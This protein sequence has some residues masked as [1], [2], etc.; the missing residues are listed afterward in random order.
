LS[1]PIGVAFDTHGNLFISE[2]GNNRI[3]RVDAETGVITTVAGNGF[4]NF[5]GDGGPATSASLNL[6]RGL[7]LDALGNL[8]IA[9]ES[10]HRIRRV[11]AATGIITTVAGN[12]FRNFSGDGDAATGASLALPSGVAL[13]AVGA[14]LIADWGNSRVRRIDADSGTIT[15]VAGS[16]VWGFSGDG[17]FAM[18]ARLASPSALALDADGILWIADSGNDRVRLVGDDVIAIDVDIK[19]GSIPNSINLL[20][21]GVLPVAILGSESFEAS[22]VDGASLT[23]APGEAAPAHDLSDPV[24]FADHLEDVNSDGIVDLVSHYRTEETDIAYGDMTACLS[25][26]TL[27]GVRFNGCDSVRTVPDMDGDQILDVDEDVAGTNALFRDS[28]GDG[29]DDGVE[30][31]TMGTDPLDALDPAPAPV[32]PKKPSRLR[33][34]RR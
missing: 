34:R 12:G 31:L 24:V 19:P 10:N 5:S 17:G 30:V 11:D 15:T 14:I 13:D 25:G 6:P 3:R 1:F 7:A 4:N 28:D 18:S 21:Q 8:F 26:S 32:E 33:N 23:F 20:E 2:Y 16:G 9:D 27:D 22:A 29:Y